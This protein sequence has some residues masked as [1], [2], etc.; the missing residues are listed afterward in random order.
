M[1]G[2]IYEVKNNENGK[3]YIGKTK[4]HYGGE[5]FGIEGR[6]KHHVTNAHTK[7]H[8][9]DCPRLYNAIRKYGKDKFSI[10]LLMECKLE[11]CDTNET[12]FIKQFNSIDRD[13][14]YNIAL[15]GKGRSIV[16]TSE[17]IREK[18]SKAQDPNGELNIKPYSKDGKVIGYR[19]KRRFNGKQYNKYFTSVE[20]SAEENLEKAK[21]Y[22]EELKQGKIENHLY[23]KAID[24]PMNINYIRH[25]KTKAIIGY[26]VDILKNGKKI[27]KSIQNATESLDKLL[28]KALL[29]KKTILSEENKVKIID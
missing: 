5:S 8:H 2:L 1:E 13:I 19:V 27:T 26:R 22:L 6:F 11:D 29:I 16:E 15:G 24:L 12:E 9:N 25:K 4:K 10:R 28:E 17:E 18:I 3:I 21:A 23:N 7:S 14:G 20:F